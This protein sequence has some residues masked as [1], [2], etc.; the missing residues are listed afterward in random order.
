MW[1]DTFL[2][3]RADKNAD[4]TITCSQDQQVEHY[5]DASSSDDEQVESLICAAKKEGLYL[6]VIRNDLPDDRRTGRIS[7]QRSPSMIFD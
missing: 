1:H 3:Y 4:Q 2:C 7:D 6:G 5:I